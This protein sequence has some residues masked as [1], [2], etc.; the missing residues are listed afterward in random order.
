M[1]DL[2]EIKKKIERVSNASLLSNEEYE[3]LDEELKGMNELLEKN[4]KEILEFNKLQEICSEKKKECERVKNSI[5]IMEESDEDLFELANNF[6]SKMLGLQEELEN[7]K[8]NENESKKKLSLIT[9]KM[10]IDS[11]KFGDL[12]ARVKDFRNKI[13]ERNEKI[14]K[15]NE[16]FKLNFKFEEDKDVSDENVNEI[17]ENANKIKTALQN[18]LD[19]LNSKYSKSMKEIELKQEKITQQISDFQSDVKQ[20]KSLMEKNKNNIVEKRKLIQETQNICQQIS[21]I[22]EEHQKLKK[23]IENLN[24]NF[25]EEELQKKVLEHKKLKNENEEKIKNITKSISLYNSQIEQRTN[26]QFNVKTCEEKK[27]QYQKIL[28]DYL[29]S[30]ESISFFDEEKKIKSSLILEENEDPKKICEYL[31]KFKNEKMKELNNTR[32]E[33]QTA[34]TNFSV[35]KKEL[36]NLNKKLVEA[37]NRE[38]EIKEKIIS[39]TGKDEKRTINDLIDQTNKKLVKVKGEIAALKSTKAL[40][41]RF[42]EITQQNEKCPLCL[43]HLDTKEEKNSEHQHE[44]EKNSVSS[45]VSHL[46]QTL[47]ENPQ[48]LIKQQKLEEEIQYAY[49][50]LN[51]LRPEFEEMQRLSETEIPKISQ[52]LKSCNEKIE[53]LENNLNSISSKQNSIEKESEKINQSFEISKTLLSDFKK[54]KE[55]QN[56]VEISLKNIENDNLES[57]EV[58]NQQ[59]SETQSLLNKTSKEIESLNKEIESKKNQIY[60][61]QKKLQENSN[62]LLEAKNAEGSI[63]SLLKEIDNLEEENKVLF[64]NIE[65]SQQ[66]FEKSSQEKEKLRSEKEKFKEKAENKIS[67]FRN[68]CDKLRE[69]LK[70]I[71]S[72]NSS[73]VFLN[74]FFKLENELKLLENSQNDDQIKQEKLKLEIELNSNV[75]EEINE[76]WRESG[77]KKLCIDQNVNLRKILKNLNEN[78]L[79]I[80]QLKEKIGNLDLENLKEKK[81]LLS[82]NLNSVG[83][84]KDQL[85]GAKFQLES[86]LTKKKRE[87]KNKDLSNIFE[88]HKRQLIQ[89]KTTELAVNDIQQYTTG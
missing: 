32:K 51:N 3:K 61:Q 80:Q 15:F 29:N 34:Q 77:K 88:S 63:S 7:A 23:N 85:N 45:L 1:N 10:Q 59:F 8:K 38:K 37:Q 4:Q 86:D 74:D 39:Y 6:D 24:H 19:E 43:K 5:E 48:L 67:K 60:S 17:L 11:R 49:D 83:T 22:E 44:E 2:K 46:E 26:H 31:L 81:N 82:K 55:A 25:K 84:R 64:S 62:K 13:N 79:K 89:L 14:K 87:I 42:I 58:L 50:K 21:S 35:E 73:R 47:K 41:T 65:I 12:N 66:N 18:K 9:E 70:S 75:I 33:F 57:I 30:I 76:K 68:N 36:E 20:K 52:N 28:S 71:S 69:S 72:F 78:Y 40:Y 27:T 16:T 53:N 54:F 56:L